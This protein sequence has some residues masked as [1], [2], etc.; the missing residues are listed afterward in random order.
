MCHMLSKLL[1]GKFILKRIIDSFSPTNHP[2]FIES[3]VEKIE[4]KFI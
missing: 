3:P 4:V 1:I 2:N